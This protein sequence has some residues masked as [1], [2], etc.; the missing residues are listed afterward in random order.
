MNQQFWNEAN[1]GGVGLFRRPDNEIQEAPLQN[2]DSSYSIVESRNSAAPGL[3]K[4]NCTAS[5][6][7]CIPKCFAEKGNR[8]LPGI[9][10]LQGP[11]GGKT[12]VSCHSLCHD[13]DR[14]SA[15]FGREHLFQFI[16][17]NSRNSLVGVQGF[18]GSE[19]LPGSKGTKGDPGP[20]GPRGVK[21][22]RGKSGIPG[23]PG[24]GGLPGIV[25]NPGA[26]GIPGTDGCNG[27]DGKNNQ[28]Y[29]NNQY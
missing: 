16:E 23:F 2:I 5:A 7:G 29:A 11:K 20:I 27:T 13:S 9:P 22:D 19:G 10:G 18:T 25:G 6:G 24:I 3:P 8:G 1:T 28:F 14:L 26:P 4:K 12:V 21:G 17:Q 15:E